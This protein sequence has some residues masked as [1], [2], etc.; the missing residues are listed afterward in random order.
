MKDFFVFGWPTL[1][2]PVLVMIGFAIIVPR[3]MARL[4][5][6]GVFYLLVIAAVSCT[7]CL[8]LS[9]LVF[10]ALY[11]VQNTQ[12]LSAVLLGG[13]KMHF[14]KLGAGA[15]IIWAPVLI[16]SV[17]SLPKLWKETIW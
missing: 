1:I 16:L 7:I 11:A 10:V 9:C 12:M 6:E 5:P 15:S 3:L 8:L 17:S 14:L 13:G 2:L 4:L